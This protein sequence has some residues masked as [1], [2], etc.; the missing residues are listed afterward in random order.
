MKYIASLLVVTL[1]IGN[2]FSQFE[3][4]WSELMPTKGRIQE[5]FPVS[6]SDF[7]TSRYQGSLLFGYNSMSKH[8][9]FNVTSSG[10]LS[11]KL[12]NGIGTVEKIEVL[13]GVPVAFISDKKD[14]ENTLYAQKYSSSCEPIGKPLRINSYKM[15]KGW[16]RRGEYWISTS[17]N[18]EFICVNYEIP[19]YKEEKDRF[20]YKVFDNDFEI[21]SEGEYEIPYPSN[22]VSVSNRYLTNKGDYFFAVKVFEL[23][24]SKKTFRSRY[25]LEKVVL[26]H[27]TP[28]GIDEFNLD[29]H[30]GKQISDLTFSSDDNQLLNFTGLFGDKNSTGT[31]GIFFF[32]LD[33][34]KKKIVSEGWKDFGKDFIT[35]DWTD[36]EKER[37][38][39]REAKGKGEPQLYQY[40]VRDIITLPNGSMIGMLE[41]YY[42]KMVT[43]TDPRT[44]ATSTTYYYYY[45]DVV[46]YKINAK[47]EFD[48]IKKINKHQVSTND[49]GYFSS[50]AHIHNDNKIHLFFN[51]NL[52]NY[53]ENGDYDLKSDKVYPT[54]Y[55]KKTNTVATV[56]VDIETGT[57]NRKTFFSRNEVKAYAVPKKFIVDYEKKEMLMLLLYGRKEKFGVLSF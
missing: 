29:F 47:G 18:K 9:N 23:D 36:R 1:M 22:L 53:D 10:K 34:D 5:I 45:N 13:K 44:G 15:P 25:N 20:G 4:K 57:I 52:R 17:R 8:T 26:F 46:L 12:E 2:L 51:D 7:Y 42:V 19:G 14:G 56:E 30:V 27:A 32:Q 33:F 3:I 37:A 41:Q 40:D 28:K 6:Y 35:D 16:K 38:E 55:R 11:S 39:K 21:I 31:K 43:R 48:W 50:I 24:Q 49:Y 54:S